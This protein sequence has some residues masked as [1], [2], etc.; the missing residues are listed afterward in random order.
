MPGYTYVWEFRVVPD[1]Q[2]AF[3]EA[4]GPSGAWAQ[5]FRRAPGYLRTELLRDRAQPDRFLTIDHWESEEAWLAFR[6]AHAPE[7]EALD[8]DCATLTLSELEIGRFEP[9]L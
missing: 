2:E 1:R 8:L 9:A 6:A 5:L 4:Y 7:Y 3:L